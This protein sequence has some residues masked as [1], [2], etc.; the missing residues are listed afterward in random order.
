MLPPTVIL[1]CFEYCFILSLSFFLSIGAF[2][3]GLTGVSDPNSAD[4]IFIF[5]G[6][7][8][9]ESVPDKKG[10]LRKAYVPK[11]RGNVASVIP[12]VFHIDVKKCT[13]VDVVTLKPSPENRYGHVCISVL[14]PDYRSLFYDRQKRGNSLAFQGGNN[15][16][17]MLYLYGGTKIDTGGYAAPHIYHLDKTITYVDEMNSAFFE[18]E[19]KDPLSAIAA[20]GFS[21]LGLGSHDGSTS[22]LGS[23]SRLSKQ[24]SAMEVNVAGHNQAHSFVSDNLNVNGNDIFEMSMWEKLEKM[25][26]MVHYADEMKK[27]SENKSQP[28]SPEHSPE[29][30]GGEGLLGGL[31]GAFG[32]GSSTIDIKPLKPKTPATYK[33][34]KL[35]LSYSLSDVVGSERAERIGGSVSQAVSMINN[36]VM[37]GTPTRPGTA[38]GLVGSHSQVQGLGAHTTG[39]RPGTSHGHGNSA[40]IMEALGTPSKARP[41][42][43]HSRS[44][45]FTPGMTGSQTIGRPGSPPGTAGSG[46]GSGVLS[47]GGERPK[48]APSHSA[49]YATTRKPYV[50]PHLIPEVE[51]YRRSLIHD[52]KVAVKK[53]ATVIRKDVL[54]KMEGCNLKQ[55]R[56]RYLTHCCPPAL[57]PHHRNALAAASRPGTSGPSTGPPDSNFFISSPQSQ[58]MKPTATASQHHHNSLVENFK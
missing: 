33:E 11:R 22:D 28:Q 9:G 1:L 51:D 39:S 46:F 23:V 42:T 56:D 5:G 55:A 3:Y 14:P 24:P 37:M 7:D 40:E 48:T 20:Q 53:N 18:E 50:H 31:S 58:S 6:R 38:Q 35:S 32:T 4:C 15:V 45:P 30:H 34:L 12:H 57:F 17:T 16:E 43:G 54:P 13:M 41:S 52:E 47:A 29:H 2:Y 25:A 27:N 44:R 21:H 49:K 10:V 8:T 26:A 36:G 19:T